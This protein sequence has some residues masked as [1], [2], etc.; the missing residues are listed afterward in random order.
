MENVD[1]VR[2]HATLTGP[3]ALEV[4][5]EA[6]RA[7]KLFLNVG[8]R[9]RVPALEGIETVPYLTNTSMMELDELPEHLVIVGA[10]Y[11]GLEFAQMFRRF[12]SEVTVVERGTRPIARDDED[13]SECVREVLER[14]GVRFRFGADCINLSPEGS[15]VRVGVLCEGQD[16]EVVGS[17]VLLAIG[18]VP[19]TDSLGLDTAGVKVSERG[20]VEVDDQLRTNVPGIW[21]LGDCNGQGAF[22]HTA[23]NDYE[24]VAS[25]LFDDDPRRTTDRILCYGLFVD[26]PLGRVGMTEVQAR[27]SGRNVLIGKRP[28]KHVGRAKERSETDGFIKILV[29]GDSKEILGAAILGIG[30]D[31]VVHSLLDLMYA[32][33]PYT[34][35]S[36]AVHIHPTVSELLPTTLQN[37]QPLTS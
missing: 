20:F 4:D 34:V 35:M 12:G 19:N 18:R 33:A 27:A 22:T 14:E 31:E 32:G 13:V 25:N 30:G 36:R 17:H 1:L 26:P 5:G 28:M 8:G 6:Y 9:A 15:G 37:L 21:A 3:D 11:I 24:I 2:G 16:P 23:Y 7:E 10:S 29:D